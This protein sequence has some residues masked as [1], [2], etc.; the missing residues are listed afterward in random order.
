MSFKYSSRHASLKDELELMGW[1]D[2]EGRLQKT[3][4]ERWLVPPSIRLVTDTKDEAL[5][6][7]KGDK[8]W[9]RAF[10]K[11]A[12]SWLPLLAWNYWDFT[13]G[14]PGKIRKKPGEILMDF[15]KLADA[16]PDAFLGF[17]RRYG[18]LE[19]CEHAHPSPGPQSPCRPTQLEPVEVWRV[20][21]RMVRSILHLVLDLHR[22]IPEF[23][24][25]AARKKKAYLQSY[26]RMRAP[27]WRDIEEA[28]L[29]FD[30]QWLGR[31][32]DEDYF[33]GGAEDPYGE[34]QRVALVINW[35]I[36]VTAIRPV[37][38]WEDAPELE[39]G[40][41]AALASVVRQ[42]IFVSARTDGVAFC[43]GCGH[44]Y[45]PKT[46]KPK[47]GQRKFCPECRKRGVPHRFAAAD[48]QKRK[49]ENSVPEKK[50]TL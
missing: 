30:G 44:P 13:G 5:K 6:I 7:S 46:R 19:L 29:F 18:I 49:G 42:L 45:V 23:N 15:C 26:P 50:E 39:L 11:K 25:L 17:A 33:R 40:G 14:E 28:F 37:F 12:R 16:P 2:D 38:N 4:P 31:E 27:K 20:Y 35:L 47:T 3:L 8:P 48:Y 43:D 22:L 24:K 1:V 34:A 41:S 10:K 9:L 32:L 36:R 21:A